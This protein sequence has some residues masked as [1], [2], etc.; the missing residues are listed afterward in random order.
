MKYVVMQGNFRASGN[1]DYW[2]V[3]E[4]KTLKEAKK[5]MKCVCDD[6]HGISKY[7]NGYLETVIMCDDEII[8]SM[9]YDY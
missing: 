4:F 5:C 3:E 1:G 2:K 7:P 6:T 8:D 9:Q